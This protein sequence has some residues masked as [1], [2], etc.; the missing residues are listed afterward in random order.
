MKNLITLVLLLF[1]SSVIGQH[2]HTDVGQNFHTEFKYV[3]SINKGITIKNS[4]PKGGEKYIDPNG[5]EYVFAIFWNCITN[6]TDADLEITINFPIDSCSVHSS[7]D[8]NF[9]F[10][11]PTEEMTI[12]KASLFNYGLD[13]KT[14]L[15]KNIYKPSKLQVTISPKDAYSFY[16]VALSNRGVNGV[17]RAGFELRKQELLYKINNYEINCGRIATKN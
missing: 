6:E 17:V 3:D 9:N 13:L 4:Y 11:L 7:P 5:K 10:Y 1:S 2:F 14:F 8:V 15:D 12:E 16:V